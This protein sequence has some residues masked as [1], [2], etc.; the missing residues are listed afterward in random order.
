MADVRYL[1]RFHVLRQRWQM[2]TLLSRVLAGLTMAVV[3]TTLVYMMHGAWWW[4]IPITILCLAALLLPA[5]SWKVTEADVIR[6]FN[7]TYPEMEESSGLLLKPYEQLTFLE[8]LQAQKTAQALDAIPTPQPLKKHL[9]ICMLAFILVLTVSAG[10]G[11]WVHMETKRAVKESGTPQK[12]AAAKENILP[13][14]SSVTISIQ[15]PAYTHK[16]KRQQQQFNLEAEEG[17]QLLWEIRTNRPVAA[18]QLVLNDTAWITLQ[19]TDKTHTQWRGHAVA[20]RAGF[21]QVQLDGKLSDLYKIAIIKDQAPVINILSPKAYTIIDYGMPTRI[22]LK[23]S[24]ADD[25]GISNAHIQ[26]TVASGSGEAVK[27]KEQPIAFGESF[28]NAGTQYTLEKTIDLAA[29]GM[30]PGSELYFYI[31]AQDN[32]RQAARSGMYMVVLPDTAQLMN[33]EGMANSMNLKPEYFRSQRQI[34][35]ETE[36]LIRDKDTLAE[37]TFQRRSNDLGIDQRLLRLRYGK[38]LGEETENNIG[39]DRLEEEHDH[40]QAPSNDAKDF[41]NAEKIIDQFSHKHDIAEDATF[42]DPA[43]KSQLKATLTEMWNA[44]RELRTY[45]PQAALPY[46][47]KALRLLKDLQQKSRAYVAKTSVRTPPLKPEKRLTGELDKII[48]PLRQQQAAL[49]VTDKMA[50]A[51]AILET[52]KSGSHLPDAVSLQVLQQA[53]RQ[54]ATETATAP[55]RYLPALQA[56]RQILSALEQQQNASPAA[57]AIAEQALYNLLPLPAH[58]PQASNA[59]ANISLSQQYFMNLQKK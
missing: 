46:E 49:A 13:E 58:L 56:M 21:Y 1:H 6:Y 3:F 59:I 24:V 23:V 32:H 16:A 4:A 9:R 12:T 39:D 18:L 45:Q 11:W 40:D 35:I 14:I 25:Y 5:Y 57:V 31:Q 51:L 38:F 47:Y 26:G 55:A 33:I 53:A 30:Q 42:F 29:L 10:I 44:E 37:K 43:T 36:Q 52:L 54:L 41:N 50:Y 20:I 27:F 22:A 7:I 19:A 34:I 17:A 48:L 28:S 2:Y 8:Q 15:P